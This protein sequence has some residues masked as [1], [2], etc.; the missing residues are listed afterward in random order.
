MGILYKCASSIVLH[1]CALITPLNGCH[2][3]ILLTLSNVVC[4]QATHHTFMPD[5]L[6]GKHHQRISNVRTYIHT[7]VC[8]YFC[9][10]DIRK[11]V[12]TLQLGVASH[13]GMH[14]VPTV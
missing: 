3:N 12:R 1:N 14:T 7:Y 2:R 8:S 11:Y 13:V 6:K 5:V 10:F 4:H 9:T